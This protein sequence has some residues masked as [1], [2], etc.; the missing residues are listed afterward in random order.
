MMG[1]EINTTWFECVSKEMEVI[2]RDKIRKTKAETR[3]LDEMRC[4]DNNRRK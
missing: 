3:L 2:K 1:A 4:N